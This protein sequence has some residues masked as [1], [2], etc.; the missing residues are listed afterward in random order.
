MAL[1]ITETILQM[2][3][4]A[5]D[6]GNVADAWSI[7]ASAGDLYAVGAHDIIAQIDNPVSVFTKITQVQWDRVA[8][9]ARQTLFMEVGQQHAM[10]Y[11]EITRGNEAGFDEN[12]EQL[13]LLPTTEDI[14]GSYR[15]ALLDHELPPLT[16][17]DSMFSVFDWSLESSSHWFYAL[18]RTGNMVD[19]SWARI[20]DPELESSR[21]VYDSEVFLNDNIDEPLKEIML[22][23]LLVRVRFGDEVSKQILAIVWDALGDVAPQVFGFEDPQAVAMSAALLVS[24]DKGMAEPEMLRLLDAISMGDDN[25]ADRRGLDWLTRNFYQALTG[26]DPGPFESEHALFSAADSLILGL[27]SDSPFDYEL[28][29]L[30]NISPEALAEMAGRQDDTGQVR[31][32]GMRW[33]IFSHL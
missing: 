6:D 10:Q 29:N 31:H 27:Q 28:I 3:E 14:E 32:V 16:A 15:S 17:V 2:A 12:G 1:R 20:L 22:T 8:P 4:Q 18:V 21:I 11:L 13:Y 33:S 9:G 23:A 7:L 19:V 26:E 30:L 24:L 5:A 25:E